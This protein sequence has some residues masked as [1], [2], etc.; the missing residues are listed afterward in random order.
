MSGALASHL[1]AADGLHLLPGTPI[2]GPNAV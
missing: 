1:A 2:Y